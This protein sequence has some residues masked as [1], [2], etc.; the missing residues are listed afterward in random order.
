MLKDIRAAKKEILLETYIYDDDKIGKKFRD[1]LIKKALEGV[2]VRLLVDAWGSDADKK[3][4]KKFIEAGGKVRFFRE[5]RY[6]I[7]F[8]NENHE[9][10]HRKLLLIDNKISYIGSINI[11]GDCLNWREL[12]LRLEDDITYSLKRTFVRSWYN[13]NKLINRRLKKIFHEDYEIIQDS[14]LKLFRPAERSYK[15]LIRKAKKEVFIETPYF[16]PSSGV[17]R[18]IRKA[19]KRGVEVKI[20]IPHSSDLRF[21]DIFR[22]RYIGRL[23]KKGVKIYFYSKVLH[24]KLL[25]IDDLFFLLGSSNLDFR[26]FRHQYEINLLGKDRKIICDLK[27]YFKQTLKGSHAFDYAKWKHRHIFKRIIEVLMKPFGRYL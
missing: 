15:K 18:A 21:L 24:S 7:R 6:V 25:I 4:F 13:F 23:H 14:P 17:R 3:F 12:V 2:K 26:S 20:I 11:T 8:F 1:E 22:N 16:V 5:I 27:E 19:V 10:N 9:R